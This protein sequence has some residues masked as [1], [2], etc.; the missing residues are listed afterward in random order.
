MKIRTQLIAGIVVFALLL[1]IISGFTIATNQQIE[2][3]IDQEELATNIALEVGELGYLSNDYILYREPQLAVRW[4]AKYAS[5]SHDIALLPADQ[6]ELQEIAT[7]LDANLRNTKSVFDDISA[8]PVQPGGSGTGFIQLSWSRMAVQN[9]GMIFDAGRLAHL[10]GDQAD[11][12]RQ[13][14]LLLIFALMG[15]FVAF[16][17]TSYF[18]GA[19]HILRSVDRLRR[20]AAIIGSG[21]FGH[22]IDESSDNEI[23]DLAR[24]FNQ[25]TTNLTT[26]LASKADLEREVTG[27]KQA[28][29]NLVRANLQLRRSEEHLIERNVHLN[30]LNEELTATQEELQQNI[31]ELTRAERNLREVSGRLESLYTS[32]NEGLAI[33]EIVYTGEEATDYIIRDVNPAYEA[34]TGIQRDAA[35]GRKASELYGTREPPYLDI[36]SRVALGV[37]P[38]HFETYF[39]S[40]AKHFAISVFSPAKG[41]FATVFSDITERKKAEDSLRETS[42]YLENLINYANAP[43]IV[44]D[45]EFRIT[46][47]NHAFELLSGLTA[48]DAIGQHLESLFPEK[49]RVESMEVIRRTIRGERMNVVEIPILRNDG[50]VRIVLWNSAT[51]YE[52]DGTTISSTIAQGQ[53]ITDRKVAEAELIEKN[54]EL[55]TAN[56][57]LAA[58]H[59]E[60]NATNAD[61]VANEHQ[62]LARNE[63]LTALNEEITA[64]QQELH[65]HVEELNQSE[66]KLRQNEVE[67]K[68][69]L[70]EKEVLLSEIH[71]RVKNNLTAFISLLSLDGSMEESPSGKALKK[72]LQNRARSMA[73][74]HDTLYRT[75]KFSK[76][77]MDFYLST[78]VGQIASSYAE[79][80]D[81]YTHVQA[82]GIAIDLAR[83]TASGLIINELVTNSFKYAFPPEFDCM[84]ERGENCAIRVSLAADNG[85]YTLTVA[86]NGRGLPP[87]LDVSTTRSLGLKLVNFLARHQLRAE[88]G[89]RAGK[90]TEFTFRL[91]DKGEF[92]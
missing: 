63:E 21:D 84:A 27:R 57:E 41:Q 43:I 58:I 24:S 22:Y 35:V 23:G 71:H 64:T 12:L 81:I 66:E 44:W 26:V 50:V 42:Q 55:S 2:K 32:M 85:V 28:E 52:A 19:R 61:L 74:I 62:L 90:G 40:M 68:Q 54:R 67:L 34:I 53:D 83:A 87:G 59:E 16:L 18:L 82:G 51:L 11:E 88:I 10:I 17:F 31:D 91:K 73:L 3:L 15:A 25:M 45:P 76:V 7:T 14:R 37:A 39:P 9:Q 80:A 65:R 92:A 1:A 46:Q 5:I 79:R 4:N 38:E 60:L 36:F 30:A 72:D 13:T 56:T 89:I 78:L 47:F 69:A 8:S 48:G 29:E 86:D 77:D 70:T 20:G 6:P 75:G 33:H 49:L